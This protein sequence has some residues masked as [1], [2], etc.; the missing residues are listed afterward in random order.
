[1]VTLR[2]AACDGSDKRRQSRGLAGTGSASGLQTP[3]ETAASEALSLVL[4]VTLAKGSSFFLCFI[5]TLWFRFSD[6]SL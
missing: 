4:L 3:G 6:I 1:M 5:F 2:E